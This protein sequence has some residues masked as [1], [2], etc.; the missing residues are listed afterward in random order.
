MPMAMMAL[1][2]PAP[3]TA[4]SMMADRIAGKAKPK[5]ASRM[6]RFLDPAAPGRGQQAERGADHQADAHRD[7]AHHDGGARA[8]QQQRGDVAAEGVGAQPVAPLGRLQLARHVH[9]VGRRAASRPATAPAASTSSRSARRRSRSWGGAARGARSRA[10]CSA[11]RAGD[12]GRDGAH[13]SLAF[14]RGSIT[15]YSTSTT[16]LTITTMAA[17]SITQLRTT[18]RSR[19]EIDWKISRPRPGR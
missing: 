8:H 16:K 9:L 6:M 15:A 19:L 17:S 11:A 1:T 10:P 2:M 4:V 5:S 12:G 18:I 3:N 7:H 14:T 13:M